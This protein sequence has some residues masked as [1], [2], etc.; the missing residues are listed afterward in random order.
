MADY[1]KLLQVP[2]GT[3]ERL[4]QIKLDLLVNTIVYAT[5]TK[6]L[7]VKLSDGN[8]EYFKNATDIDARLDGYSIVLGLNASAEG[9]S[10]T[11]LG[12]NT[13]AAGNQ[14]T[15]LGQEANAS[16]GTSTAL[17]SSAYAEG[18]SSIA[19]GVGTR[20]LGLNS[21]AIGTET[22]V[23]ED[24]VADFGSNRQVRVNL[25]PVNNR[26]AVSKAH[27]EVREGQLNDTIDSVNTDLSGRIDS[28]ESGKQDKLTAGDNITIDTNNK[29]SASGVVKSI[30]GQTPNASG[31]VQFS[32]AALNNKPD[33]FSGNYNDLT[34][35]PSIPDV[36][37]VVTLDEE[38]T[39]SG[40]KTFSNQIKR[41]NVGNAPALLIEGTG[42]VT[43]ADA[44]L[45]KADILKA[46]AINS[47]DKIS[48]MFTIGWYG[49]EDL[50]EVPRPYYMFLD[51]R[52]NG[53]YDNATLKVDVEDRV[54]V[55]LFNRPTE[56]L[57]V[58]GKIR[59]R[60][61]TVAG[62][63]DD[64]VVTKGFVDASINTLN[65][66][67]VLIPDTTFTITQAHFNKTLIITSSSDVTI[68]VPTQI[69]ESI[70]KGFF[71]D[72][73]RY[74]TGEVSFSGAGIVLNSAGQL[75]IDAQYIAASLIKIDDN[76][77]WLLIGGRE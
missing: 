13:V 31:L 47:N 66:D 34:N 68:T 9:N 55:A 41:T 56:A 50:G 17:G 14:S 32:Y 7:G 61:Q 8:I 28:V 62:D 33:L 1:D 36:S 57:D 27:L 65:H 23:T 40:A 54:G 19:L 10:S 20:A 67:I 5:D 29:I 24:N 72:I 4:E 43:N 75:S 45:I 15:A 51:A 70:E 21:I 48:T 58:G 46:R 22:E 53:N 52:S 63:A 39:I 64:I 76:N 37:N 35:K 11:A 12:L 26:D 6:E 74:G 3:K 30:N 69:V 49:I 25:T 18:L 2:R 71:C 59:M 16:G 44:G 38:Q 60:T 77:E 42:V 73:V